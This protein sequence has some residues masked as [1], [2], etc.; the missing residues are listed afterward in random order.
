MIMKKWLLIGLIFVV[1]YSCKNDPKKEPLTNAL[2]KQEQEEVEVIDTMLTNET[3]SF[4][5]KSG[6]SNFAKS[7]LKDF[8]W[9]RFH[10]IDTWK[11]DT[12]T[13]AK[14]EPDKA[15]FENYGRFLKY[16]PDSSFVIDLD[17]YNTTI[18]KNKDGKLIGREEGPD[19]EISLID[20]KNKEKKRL[21]FLGPG[22]SI[23]EGGWIDEDNLAL[24]GLQDTPDESVQVHLIWKYHLPTHTF[25]LF[26]STDT[27]GA[28]QQMNSWRKE[29]LKGVIIQ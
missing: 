11:D 3:I 12:V 21:V 28:Q 26:Q 29:R 25:Y 19:T 17:S 5:N 10:M 16:S 2:P 14:F 15:Y 9:S 4:F 22:G 23:E 27:I 24:I 13:S 20:L 8:D 18:T 7:R 6:Y 1:F